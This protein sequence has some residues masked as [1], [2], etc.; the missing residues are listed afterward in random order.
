VGGV[1]ARNCRP[2]TGYEL[3]DSGDSDL[4]DDPTMP[5][6][7]VVSS[8][9]PSGRTPSRRIRPWPW[10]AL[11]AFVLIAVGP[12]ASIA[13]S[14][15]DTARKLT[16]H[17]VVGTGF[18]AASLN[19][20]FVQR[21]DGHDQSSKSARSGAPPGLASDRTLVR[22]FDAKVTE[23][24][25]SLSQ[26]DAA[27]ITEARAIGSTDLRGEARD[28]AT[29]QGAAQQVE[30]GG[31]GSSTCGNAED[32]VGDAQGV[33][34]EA[35]DVEWDGE[36]VV[37]DIN[38]ARGIRQE[39]RVLQQEFASLRADEAKQ[40]R[41]TRASAPTEKDVNTAV[42]NANSAIAFAISMT[43]GDVHRA[44]VD[45]SAAYQDAADAFRAGS[46]GAP[47][48]APAPEPPFSASSAVDYNPRFA[49]WRTESPLSIDEASAEF[50]VPTV[51]SGGLSDWVGLGGGADVFQAGAVSSPT[52]GINCWWENYPYNDQVA[53]PRLRCAPGDLI[54]A[55]VAQSYYGPT[56]SR[57]IVI[58]ETT[59]Q[60]TGWM[61]VYTPDLAPAPSAYVMVEGNTSLGL[62]PSTFEGIGFEAATATF[63]GYNG[64]GGVP[65]TFGQL[66]S[67]GWIADSNSLASL[68]PGVTLR[69]S[70]PDDDLSVLP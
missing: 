17:P 8:L 6:V 62:P 32:V 25:G 55:D 68:I 51:S 37:V 63:G 49:G 33:A 40:P 46:C 21:N 42:A 16:T 35:E 41:S 66:N 67:D 2:S 3:S 26:I 52:Y 45:L 44:N 36:V 29:T 59:G 5:E 4:N 69:T 31:P 47:P 10:V 20:I 65:V 60:S 9:S 13:G 58:D 27:T 43:N 70:W 53:I 39:T 38:G 1:R 23:S 48:A 54:F 28:L 7:P 56:E 22:T 24:I 14:H 30:A 64:A 12:S 57:V 50:T 19:V 11:Q 61:R 34:G 18:L 15:A